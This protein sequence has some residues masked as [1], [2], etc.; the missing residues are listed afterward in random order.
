MKERTDEKYMT[1]ITI[2]DAP[3]GSGKTTT[4]LENLRT[5]EKYLYITP[6]LSEV[7]RVI[8]KAPVPFVQPVG[9][10]ALHIEVL[11]SE[12]VNIATTHAS[13]SNLSACDPELFSGYTL[14]IDEAIETVRDYREVKA[15]DLNQVYIEGGWVTVNDDHKIEPTPKWHSSVNAVSSTLSKEFYKDATNSNLYLFRDQFL[16]W[17]LPLHLLP[18]FM[19]VR[20]LTYMWDAS[21]AAIYLKKYGIQVEVKTACDATFKA[22][23]KKLLTLESIPAIEAL[24][25]S[26]TA[27]SNHTDAAGKKVSKSLSNL[28]ARELKGIPASKILLT[29]LES[30]WRKPFKCSRTGEI[31]KRARGKYATNSSLGK[32]N[33]L[34]SKTRAT[35]DLSDCSEVI[36]LYD[37]HASNHLQC[38]LEA[39]CGFNDRFALSELIQFVWRS[40]IR[41]GEPITLY[42]PSPRMRKLLLTWLAS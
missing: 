14:I 5:D 8:E 7:E 22:D 20:I 42:L 26:A 10:K 30:N 39:D 9:S 31:I 16:L 6:L 11:L 34:A 41:K 28:K 27:Q 4:E 35:N 13:F 18:A 24:G 2:I 19:N 33:W 40:R 15:T 1:N 29:S 21:Y 32:A 3:C 23:I 38:W 12:G 36:Y 17:E 37:K 25:W